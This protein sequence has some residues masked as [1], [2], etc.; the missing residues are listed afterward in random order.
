MMA[1]F[2]SVALIVVTVQRSL[3]V[4]SDDDGDIILTVCRDFASDAEITEPTVNKQ[5]KRKQ[6]R[7]HRDEI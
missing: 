5:T 7:M 6:H 3:C 1:A 4:R 2:S